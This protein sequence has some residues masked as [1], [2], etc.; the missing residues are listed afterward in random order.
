MLYFCES[1]TT[2]FM[3][4]NFSYWIFVNL[5][6]NAKTLAYSGSEAIVTI[7]QSAIFIIYVFTL[8]VVTSLLY[9]CKLAKVPVDI[10]NYLAK[11]EPDQTLFQSSHSAHNRRCDVANS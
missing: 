8:S 1:R 5:K 2:V 4:N 7:L 3:L 11:Y 10:A 6:T 9:L